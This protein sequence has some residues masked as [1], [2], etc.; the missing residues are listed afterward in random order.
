MLKSGSSV[1]GRA[2]R[3]HRG[4][5]D[6]TFLFIDG[7]IVMVSDPALKP[8]I[9]HHGLYIVFIGPFSLTVGC[10]V[11]CT[12]FEVK[13][14]WHFFAIRNRDSIA[15][16]GNDLTSNCGVSDFSDIHNVQ[17]CDLQGL[18]AAW[19]RPPWTAWT[20]ALARSTRMGRVG[21]KPFS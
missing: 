4:N 10:P 9:W 16:A 15:I 17:Y 7:F 18:P 3:F 21:A 14:I 6:G 19:I 11:L 2:D 5:I 1:Q 13:R 12:C 8:S 20:T